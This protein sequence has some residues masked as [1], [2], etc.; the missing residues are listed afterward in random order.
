MPEKSKLSFIWISPF[1]L[2]VNIRINEISQRIANK[3]I[4]PIILTNKKKKNEIKFFNDK[5]YIL[6]FRNPIF[7]PFK[8][9]FLKYF[10]EAI[11]KLAFFLRGMPLLYSDIKAFLKHNQNINFIYATGPS[12][13]THI[14]GYLLKK[15]FHLPLVIE[16]TDP[17][18]LN[19][20]IEGKMR[21]F[22]KQ[23]DY[24]IERH[25]LH[26]ADIIVS[27]SDFLNSLLKVNF[28]FIKD[29]LI[30]S[31]Q[32]G[33][34]LHESKDIIKKDENKIIITYAGSIYGRRN[35]VPLFKIISDLNKEKFFEEI[36]IQIKIYGNYPKK[37]F[38][39]IINKL[40]IKDLFYL[41]DILPRSK[42]LEEIQKSD[43]TLHIGED[44]DY[45]TIAFKV[46][47][48]L[49]CKKKILF[50][51]PENTYRA[52]FIRDNDLGFILPLKNSQKAKKVFKN[53][54]L[55][56]KSSKFDLVLDEAKLSN[57]SWD[58][59]ARQFIQNIIN[60]INK[61]DMQ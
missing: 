56:I 24:I 45:P 27:N 6:R 9:K 17:W 15:K 54:L 33:L 30:F 23:I 53:L 36:Q 26:S 42:V 5:S 22:Q 58:N 19:P 4:L 61:F 46:W 59:R 20:Y 35:I 49:S 40:N 1:G 55:G 29:K 32:D 39:R 34:V 43:L 28:P 31:I 13:F 25:I 7:Y 14:L 3:S 48:Y 52:N 12:F 10:R 57:F 37:S 21:W 51:T 38:E 8:N 50:L 2:L 18:Y 44:L 60:S 47:E 16:Y 41:G 11:L